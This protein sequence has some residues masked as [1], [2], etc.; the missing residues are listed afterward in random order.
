MK[1]AFDRSVV[2]VSLFF[3]PVFSAGCANMSIFWSNPE[4]T[5]LFGQAPS[6]VNDKSDSSSEPVETA[7]VSTGKKNKKD[8]KQKA[9]ATEPI[10]VKVPMAADVVWQVEP[11]PV[12]RYHIYYGQAP[13][14][15]DRHIELNESDIVRTERA[16]VG[17]VYQYKIE[18]P[19]GVSELFVSVQAENPKGRSPKSSPVKVKAK[20]R[21]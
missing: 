18:V 5:K 7:A 16:N 13:G 3:L 20:P 9:S 12:T 21:R 14:S 17:R 11:E 10:K 6:V 2:W 19:P 1:L 4:F 8:K 15:L